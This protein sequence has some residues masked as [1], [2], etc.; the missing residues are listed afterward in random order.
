MGWSPSPRVGIVKMLCEAA[1]K[2]R[3]WIVV[4]D[5]VMQTNMF[6]FLKQSIIMCERMTLNEEH[7]MFEFLVS[8][9]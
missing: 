8:N 4:S 6:F 1:L 3:I 5:W 7:L 2:C 9:G